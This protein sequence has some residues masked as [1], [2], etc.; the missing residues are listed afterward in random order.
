MSSQHHL[1]TTRTARYFTLGELTDSTE[2]I[3]IV[4]HGYAQL[5]SDFIKPFEVLDNNKTFIIAPEGLNRF[6]AKGFGGKPAATW[7]TSE[8]RE[9][10]INDY[11]HYLDLLYNTLNI[12]SSKAK[13]IVLG[14]SQGVATA[15]R[16]ILAT[17]S[18]IDHFIIYAGE[19]AAELQSPLSEKINALPITYAT[20]TRD[21]LINSEKQAQVYEL[22]KRLNAT[23]IE[24]DGG[25][26]ILE[27]VIKSIHH[28]ITSTDNK[29]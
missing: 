15:S 3:W 11:I 1:Q 10:E 13:I 7:M 2:E 28:S 25:H 12:Q 23:I 5:A 27:D 19:I 17:T 4:L 22:M 9:A 8:N 21:R 18:H 6:Y 26:E 20:G 14:F 29:S 16:W 24:F